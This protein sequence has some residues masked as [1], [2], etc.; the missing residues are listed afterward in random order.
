MSK[1][2]NTGRKALI[3]TIIEMDYEL[4]GV[5]INKAYDILSKF[6]D[7]VLIETYGAVYNEYYNKKEDK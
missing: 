6:T 5:D 3:Q 2:Y 1:N 4:T 7:T